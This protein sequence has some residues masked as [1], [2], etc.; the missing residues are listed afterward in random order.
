MYS[1]AETSI[2]SKDPLKPK[3]GYKKKKIV[4]VT[5]ITTSA[6]WPCPPCPVLIFESLSLKFSWWVSLTLRLALTIT[7]HAKRQAFLQT[8]VLAAVPVGSVDQTVPLP[9]T[10]VHGIVLL[11][12]S[13]KTLQTRNVVTSVYRTDN[14]RCGFAWV[15]PG[16][17]WRT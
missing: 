5:K 12:A 8:T 16:I 9:W 10:W 15:W 13:E 3:K 6:L 4:V 2:R 14:I 17:E 7:A 11:A 1:V